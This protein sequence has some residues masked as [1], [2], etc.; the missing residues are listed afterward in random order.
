MN[1]PFSILFYAKRSKTTTSGL[2]PINIRVT[3][4]G[5][6]IELSTQRYVHPDK[7]SSEGNR[8]KGTTAEAKSIN[9]YLD[10]LKSKI[11][12]HQQQLL[13]ENMPITFENMR[14]KIFGIE[15]RRY[16]LIPIYQQHNNE[17]EA[18]I[19]IEE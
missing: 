12:D 3:I 1:T 16:M 14:N 4:D 6:R 19:G 11:Y 8:V 15:K 9:T 18:L 5:R 7:W 2:V 10:T 17:I 13:R